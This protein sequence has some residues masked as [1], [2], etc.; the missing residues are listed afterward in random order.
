MR[1]Q[2][3]RAYYCPTV[4]S[5]TR[6]EPEP[7]LRCRTMVSC[8][9]IAGDCHRDPTVDRKR[10]RPPG[11]ADW[12]KFFDCAVFSGILWPLRSS[13]TAGKEAESAAGAAFRLQGGVKQRKPGSQGGAVSWDTDELSAG[14]GE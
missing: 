3:A 12:P 5:K 11:G 1:Q 6:P 8:P 4:N 13:F 7:P 14:G 9:F 10:V 2:T